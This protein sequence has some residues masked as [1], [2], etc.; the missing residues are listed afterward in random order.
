MFQ[1][2]VPKAINFEHSEPKRPNNGP[3]PVSK[4]SKQKSPIK[5]YL[6]KL[7]QV[8]NQTIA[9]ENA[10]E[11]LKHSMRAFLVQISE[12]LENTHNTRPVLSR[13]KD[14]LVDLAL[15]LENFE[16]L[17]PF[18]AML[19]KPL[20]DDRGSMVSKESKQDSSPVISTDGDDLVDDSDDEEDVH[21]DGCKCSDCSVVKR[22]RN[23][24]LEIGKTYLVSLNDPNRKRK[25]NKVTK[26]LKDGPRELALYGVGL[27]TLTFITKHKGAKSNT[28]TVLISDVIVE[29]ISSGPKPT[30]LLPQMIIEMRWE[31]DPNWY[32]VRYTPGVDGSQAVTLLSDNSLFD[33]DKND[34]DWRYPEYASLDYNDHINVLDIDENRVAV[35]TEPQDDGHSYVCEWSDTKKGEPR[36]FTMDLWYSNVR[37]LDESTPEDEQDAQLSSEE[38]DDDA[39]YEIDD[40]IEYMGSKYKV[41]SVNTESEDVQ[42]ELKSKDDEQIISVT[43]TQIYEDWDPEYSEGAD[44]VYKNRAGNIVGINYESRTYQ[45][46]MDDEEEL[47]VSEQDLSQL[48][49]LNM[50]RDLWFSITMDFI[51]LCPID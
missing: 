24:V 6:Q 42:Y 26:L 15:G 25:L 45:I 35:V 13:I 44:I 9:S 27:E 18:M 12:L 3:E 10:S 1:V 11:G 2:H 7:L 48:N 17:K 4:K 37:T 29:P 38:E 36:N 16:V 47:D 39:D 51:E 50:M 32:L 20:P 49:R 31:G 40:V 23:N 22:Q 21:D 19:D 14:E 33:F 30:E 43:Q 8:L 46:Q 5:D 34:D 41:I 28:G